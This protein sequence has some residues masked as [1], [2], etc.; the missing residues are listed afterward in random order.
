MALPN[1]ITNRLA[2]EPGGNFT[3]LRSDRWARVRCEPIPVAARAV[4]FAFL[5]CLGSLH[6]WAQKD[7]HKRIATDMIV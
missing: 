7:D 1:R 5:L 6:S 4:V 3:H 2:I